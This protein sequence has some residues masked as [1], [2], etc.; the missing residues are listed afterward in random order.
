MS[1]INSRIIRSTNYKSFCYFV[2]FAALFSSGFMSGI[3]WNWD[4]FQCNLQINDK[5]AKDLESK[6]DLISIEKT[7]LVIVIFSAFSNE[8]RRHAIR[9]TWIRLASDRKYKHYFIVGTLDLNESQLNSL[10]SEQR[11]HNDLILFSHLKD[12]YSSLSHKLL[13]TLKWFSNKIEFKYLLKVDDDSFV[14]IDQLFDELVEK[15]ISKSDIKPLYWGYFDGRAHVKR[16]GQWS[17]TNWILCD[18]YLPYALGGGYVISKQL[19]RFVAQN[20]ELLQLYRSEDV[21]LGVWLSPL[22]INRV[23]DIRFDTEYQSRGCIN[24]HIITHKQSA[25]N[26]RN[27]YENLQT[28]GK[29]CKNEIELQYSYIYNWKTI[30]SQCCVRNITIKSV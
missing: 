29:L 2:G 10:Y 16:K 28:F 12:T 27:L 5:L 13:S 19:V 25:D 6:R 21:S 18:R 17:E 7:Y 20:A 9:Q 1:R 30:P 4:S 22:N 23:H 8:E 11:L 14:Q 3:L 15:T 26:M 24:S